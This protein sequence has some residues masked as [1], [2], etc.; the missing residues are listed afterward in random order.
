VASLATYTRISGV[1]YKIA[2][3]DL[4]TNTSDADGDART[5]TAVGSST[6]GATITL[7]GPWINY[8]RPPASNANSNAADYF[9]YT[10]SDGYTGGTA[11][12]MIRMAVTVTNVGSPSANLIALAAASNGIAV[13]F[14]G[15]PGFTHRVQRMTTVNGTNTGWSDLGTSTVNGA[16]KGAFTDTSPPPGQAYYRTAWP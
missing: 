14:V 3:S 15:I 10:I 11:S 13:N 12:G 8:V 16:G 1:S 2:I 4:L 5:V 7:S 9:S 6:N